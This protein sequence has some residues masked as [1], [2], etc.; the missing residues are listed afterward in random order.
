MVLEL[1]GGRY[2][3]GRVGEVRARREERLVGRPQAGAPMRVAAEEITLGGRRYSL[4]V[5]LATTPKS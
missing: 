1:C 5:S 4:A 3:A 2:G